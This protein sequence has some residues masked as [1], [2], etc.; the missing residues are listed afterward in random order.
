MIVKMDFR[1][2]PARSTPDPVAYSELATEEADA[3]EPWTLTN[4]CLVTLLVLVLL[5]FIKPIQIHKM[6]DTSPDQLLDAATVLFPHLSDSPPRALQ[7]PYVVRERPDIQSFLFDLG[8]SSCACTLQWDQTQYWQRLFYGKKYVLAHVMTAFTGPF[9]VPCWEWNMLYKVLNEVLEELAMPVNGK[10][11]GTGVPMDLE[12]RYDSLV[13]DLI[14]SGL[15]FIILACHAVYVLG[16]PSIAIYKLQWDVQSCQTLFTAFFQY[17]TLQ[18]VQTL[19]QNFG[20]RTFKLHIFGLSYFPGYVVAFILQIAYLRLLW[21]MRAWPTDTYNKT[22]FLLVLLWTP[23]IFFTELDNYH[24]QIQAI[25]SFALTGIAVSAF[26]YYFL[27]G[28]QKVMAA[29]SICYG[30]ALLF[31]LCLQLGPIIAAPEEQFYFKNHACGISNR[32]F[33]DSCQALSVLKSF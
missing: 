28:N 17:Y 2:T 4:Q 3:V 12:T 23:F 8:G 5:F 25:L 20:M 22:V 26:Q 32:S 30:L 29:A 13:N 21:L 18:F 7:S 15:V 10:W 9:F 11:A 6:T 14:L 1:G 33:T 27:I 19:W 31:Y 24:E 16:L